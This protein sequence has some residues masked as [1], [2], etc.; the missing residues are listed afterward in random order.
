MNELKALVSVVDTQASVWHFL[1]KLY[2]FTV[3]TKK[4]AHA[5]MTKKKL[6]HAHLYAHDNV[7]LQ[8]AR[9][10]GILSRFY[11][12]CKLSLIWIQISMNPDCIV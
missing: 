4:L 5:V 7:L 2:I 10:V 3:M 6:A 11:T 12:L 9:V 1:K 8:D